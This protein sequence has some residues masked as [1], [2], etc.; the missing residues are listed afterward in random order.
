MKTSTGI[1]MMAVATLLLISSVT[2]HEMFEHKKLA[3]VQGT[4]VAWYAWITD[5]FSMLIWIISAI[6]VFPVGAVSTLFG[7]PTVYNDMY[8][9]VVSGWFKLTL[10]GY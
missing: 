1:L 8:H 9:G 4:E 10:S 3:K 2:S 6:I 5:Q 7:A